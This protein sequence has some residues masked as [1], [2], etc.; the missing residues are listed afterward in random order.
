MMEVV[1]H[2]PEDLYLECDEFLAFIGIYD[3]EQRFLNY[4]KFIEKMNIK[5][6]VCIEAGAGFGVF[7]ELMLKY[8]AKKVYAVE[9]NRFMVNILKKKFSGDKRV[10]VVDKRIEEFEP[11]EDID[12]LL[13]DFFGI[14]LYDESLESLEHLRFTPKLL[15]P[16]SG[17]LMFSVI[18]ADSVCDET[19]TKDVL[20][21]LKGVL[22]SDLFMV[23]KDFLKRLNGKEV[24]FWDWR[25]GLRGGEADISSFSG[26]LLVFWIE[27][28]HHGELIC[29]SEECVNWPLV[30]TPRAGDKF[31]LEFNG[32]SYVRFKWLK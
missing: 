5:N 4:K 32:E 25:K 18:D 22:V 23:D 17:R 14:M 13:H 1:N 11:D 7:T 19:I 6:K 8:G 16:D 12:F 28:L 31:K 26:D 29:R 24:L 15:F 2:L 3:D 27:I 30:W 10:V 20:Q 9:K 21:E